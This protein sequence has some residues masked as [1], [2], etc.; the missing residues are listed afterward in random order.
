MLQQI[1]KTRLPRIPWSIWNGEESLNVPEIIEILQSMQRSLSSVKLT[2][3]LSDPNTIAG[4]RATCS[5]HWFLKWQLLQR[6]NTQLFWSNRLILL[7]NV[8][9][10]EESDFLVNRYLGNYVGKISSYIYFYLD[11]FIHEL[12][13]FFAWT[14]ILSFV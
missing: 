12:L 3:A 2:V 14:H 4:R 8:Y 9:S 1:F 7:R 11:T 6:R 13:I 5:L 10:N